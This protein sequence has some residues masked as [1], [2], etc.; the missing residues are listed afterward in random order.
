MT[1][2]RSVAYLAC[3]GRLLW[4]KPPSKGWVDLNCNVVVTNHGESTAIGGCVGDELG[5]FI[6]GFASDVGACSIT[7]AEIRA[8]YTSLQLLYI[9]GYFSFVVESDSMTTINLI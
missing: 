9:R 4:W 1:P 8:I 7:E 2:A 3:L 5:N 6:F